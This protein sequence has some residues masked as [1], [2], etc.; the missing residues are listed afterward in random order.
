VQST[1]CPYLGLHDDQTLIRTAPTPSHRC[2][3]RHPAAKPDIEFQARYCL[4]AGHLTCPFFPEHAAAADEGE[5]V[6]NPAT[7]PTTW[8]PAPAAAPIPA[9]N[10][11]AEGYLPPADDEDDFDEYEQPPRAGRRGWLWMLLT[12]VIVAVFALVLV[13]FGLEW[14]RPPDNDQTVLALV[15]ATTP[16]Q[17]PSPTATPT[18]GA[19][20][21]AGA[22]PGSAASTRFVTPTPV[23]DGQ[24]LSIVPKN[25][26]AGWWATDDTRANHLGDSFL[27]AGA[28]QGQSFLANARFDLA[29]V[30]RGAIIHQAL[31]RATGLDDKRFRPLDQAV[32]LVQLLPAADTPELAK[33]DYLAALSAPAAITLPPLRAADLAAG[34]T[35]TLELDEP[36]RRWLEEQ[37]LA[38]ATSVTVRIQPAD[39]TQET[40]FAWD[41]GMGPQT[42]GSP[43]ELLLSLGPPLPTP[44]PL[45]TK[46]FVVATLTPVPEN[47]LTVVAQANTATAVAA[48]TGTYTPI[49]Y[50]VYTPTPFPTNLETAQAVA[51]GRGLPPVLL[52]TPTPANEAT[53]T[54]DAFYATAVALTT[55]T[56][57][58]MPSEWVTP[59]V[60][61]PSPPA[62][63]VAT[64]AARVLEETATAEAAA[65]Q[66][67]PT[68]TST[69]LPYN[70]VIGV[71]VYATSVPENLATAIAFDRLLEDYARTTGTPT[72]LPWNALI[73][74]R[75]PT[76]IVVPPTSTPIPLF[77][78]ETDFTPTPT[79]TE[80]GTPPA[81]LP[82]EVRG[83]ILFK[84]DRSGQEGIY[85]LDPAS[86]TVTLI[87]QPWV[88]TLARRQLTLAP[89]GQTEAV[90]L[91][92]DRRILQIHARNEVYGTV[93]QVTALNGANYDPAWSPTG[94]W[95]AFVST[96][97]GGDEIYRVDPTGAVAQRLTFNTWE[98]DKHPTWSPDGSQIVF[99]SNR[100]SGRRQL[101]IMNAD[102]TGQQNLTNDEYN[103]WDP[104][105]V[106]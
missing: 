46:P 94:E 86:G 28:Y 52:A 79:P 80:T 57:T 34:Q 89:D 97:H 102:G 67:L 58:P 62:E 55:G 69:A 99:F 56:F 50:Q 41:S 5:V 59:V 90:V 21:A 4:A 25:G 7:V 12:L 60:I 22:D 15:E 8:P 105:W 104:V 29:R 3:A 49:P 32:W 47:V 20:A 13:S 51:L 40:L 17:P 24:V 77:I 30:P 43:P 74:T 37:L 54:A 101:W 88:Y 70:A 81:E 11:M 93:R 87:T 65:G 35:N 18:P 73:I 72:P 16:T 78:P 6:R 91:A 33:A 85:M 27:Y 23:P 95:I 45:P 96:E 48:A 82:A 39:A 98:W 75:V 26:E 64:A 2:Y 92:D 19:A 100:E 42:S 10:H 9:P 38:G 31:L 76:P 106:R 61:P 84:S 44:P 103:N 14:L 36:A 66:I 68:P 53:A 1:V 83:K 63:N 71:Y